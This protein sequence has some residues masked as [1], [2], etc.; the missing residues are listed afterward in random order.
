MKMRKG[1][2]LLLAMVLL[3][4]SVIG[5]SGGSDSSSQGNTQGGTTASAGKG[6]PDLSKKLTIEV[7]TRSFAGGGWGDSHPVLD[8]LNKKFNIDLKMQ[9]V[10]GPNYK[11]KLNVLAASNDFPDLY[12]IDKESF[13]KWKERGAFLDMAPILDNYPN[14]TKH[15]SKETL[16][17]GNP[18]GKLLSLPYTG[19]AARDSIVVRKD[20]LDKLNLK[21]PTTI[22]EYMDVARAFVNGDPDGNGKKDTIGITFGYKNGDLAMEEH[23]RYAFGLPNQFAEKD[24]KLVP[25]QEFLPQWKAFAGFMNEA[26]AEGVIDKD[27]PIS[28]PS[29]T[30]TKF[31][32]GKVG[33]AY[34]NPN[35]LE[36]KTLPALKKLDPNAEIIQL[37]PPVGPNG[38]QGQRTFAN[39]IEKIVINAKTDAQKQERVLML[40][41]YMLS[42]EGTAL[43]GNG[44]EGVHYK[45]E[46]S[47]YTKLPAYESDRPFLLV[48]WLFRR[49]DPLNQMKL[50]DN[51]DTVNMIK[52]YFDM[53]EKYKVP[54]PADGYFS[55]TQIKKGQDLKLKWTETVTKVIMGSSPPEEFDK[56]YDYWKK[57]GGEEIVKEF[58][59]QYQP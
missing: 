12:W 1:T 23:F 26:Y 52:G 45:K 49:D 8:E 2:S 53:N 48:A 36:N 9:W 57:N 4:G 25:M 37:A 32:A 16:E 43:I 38:E 28:G 18:K 20:W 40:L 24:G 10:P 5:C 51:Q 3:A 56:A 13:D 39:G 58:N 59:E 30:I 35:E 11:E 29:D 50:F 17:V 33:I 54:N 34:V 15:L 31:E 19:V 47:S 7:M 42:D 22:E 6:E 44:I 14:L 41:D 21:V 55:E 46:G 27:F